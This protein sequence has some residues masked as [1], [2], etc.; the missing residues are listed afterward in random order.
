MGKSYTNMGDKSQNSFKNFKNDT[1]S[2]QNGVMKRNSRSA[3]NTRHDKLYKQAYDR[4][5]KMK[6]VA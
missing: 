1:L 2:I 3:I 6:K 4:D 5:M